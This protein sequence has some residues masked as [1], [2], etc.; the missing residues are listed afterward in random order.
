MRAGSPVNWTASRAAAIQSVIGSPAKRS[1]MRASTSWMSWGL[2]EIASQ[3]NG[4][5][6][7]QNSGRM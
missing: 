5:M 2:P 3:R 1:R 7:W 4:P 6:P